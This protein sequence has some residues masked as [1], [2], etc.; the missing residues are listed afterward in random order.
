MAARWEGHHP[1]VLN[2]LSNERCMFA[3]QRTALS[4]GAA[5]V[6]VARFFSDDGLLTARVSIGYLMLAIAGLVWFDGA[7][8]YHRRAEAIREDRAL[9][10]SDS[11]IRIV[12]LSTTVLGGLI[13]AIELLL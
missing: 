6:S 4:W 13:V 2:S 3:W 7:R 1:N 11:A 5:G 9:E 10:P 12:A 8:R